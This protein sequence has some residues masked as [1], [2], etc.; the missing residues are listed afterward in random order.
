MNMVVAISKNRGIGLNNKIPWRLVKDT[1]FFK[2]LTIGD[3][4]NA[5]VMGK[6]TFL[7][8]KNPLPYRDN[9]V[10]SKTLK[11]SYKKTLITDEGCDKIVKKYYYK[12]DN[13]YLIGG[14]QIYSSYINSNLVKS[15]YI[16][17]IQKEF[18]CD[19][20]FPEIPE[21]FD[22]VY[23]MEFSDV[24]KKTNEDIIFKIHILKNKNFK[25]DSNKLID[26][27]FKA[28]DKL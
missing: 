19:T 15:I 2:H 24:N 23:G 3:K 8:L 7:S 9:F 13:I 26:E 4:N 17:E 6:N 12:Y 20:F 11:N 21:N 28:F 25:Q 1:K 18:H 22:S 10:L 5:V 14:D 16:T 27:F